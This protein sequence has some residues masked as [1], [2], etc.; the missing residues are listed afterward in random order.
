MLSPA[1][2]PTAIS[3]QGKIQGEIKEFPGG[4]AGYG[5]RI[6]TDV[7]QVSAV[8]QFRSLALGTSA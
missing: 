2:G 3:Y 4:S 5:S 7:A 8:P 6:V 1:W